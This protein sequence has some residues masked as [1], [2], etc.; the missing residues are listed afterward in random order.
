MMS[1]LKIM[2]FVVAQTFNQKDHNDVIVSCCCA[3]VHM[4]NN[5]RDEIYYSYCIVQLNI[6][7]IKYT[8]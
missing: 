7:N 8:H 3:F 5:S 2:N 4:V 6:H 1:L